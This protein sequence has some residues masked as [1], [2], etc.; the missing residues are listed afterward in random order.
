MINKL[1]EFLATE[2]GAKSPT[3]LASSLIDADG[4]LKEDYKTHLKPAIDKAKTAKYD[5]GKS[6]GK[7]EGK[8]WAERELKSQWEKEISE[9]LGVEAAPIKDMAKAYSDKIQAGVKTK[10]ITENDILNHPA[11]LKIVEKLNGDLETATTDLNTRIKASERT[12]KVGSLSDILKP[13]LEKYAITPKAFQKELTAYVEANNFKD[14]GGAYIPID[15]NG[16]PIRSSDNSEVVKIVDH[17]IGNHIN[18][19]Y[20]PKGHKSDTPGDKGGGEGGEGGE[21]LD[22]S[23][24][25]SVQDWSTAINAETDSDKKMELVNASRTWQESQQN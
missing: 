23:K 7:T 12:E 15:A 18:D 14:D 9:T 4:N 17:F 25:K 13:V 16:N 3:E 2:L 11:H 6:D 19:Y 20:L 8:G 21:K 24:Y 5:A 1:L 10:E 22:V